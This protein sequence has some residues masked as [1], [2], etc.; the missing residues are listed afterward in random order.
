MANIKFLCENLKECKKKS[1]KNITK[2]DRK[3]APTFIHT[4]LLPDLKFNGYCL[5]NMI[6]DSGKVIN[7]C[8][9]ISYTLDPWSKDFVVPWC[10]GYHYCTTSFN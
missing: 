4:N 3:F 9:Y 8:I 10:S 6:P 7:I 5:I 2:S 1:I